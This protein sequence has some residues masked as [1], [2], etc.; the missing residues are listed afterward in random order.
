MNL[1]LDFDQRRTSNPQQFGD[2][3]QLFLGNIPHHATEEELKALFSRFGQVIDLRI[4]SKG[5]GKLPPGARNPLNYGFITYN[6]A[7]AA[8]NCLAN[9]VS[10]SDINDVSYRICKEE[11]EKVFY[12]QVTYLVLLVL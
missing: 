6:D 12:H 5:N 11:L 3:Q 9:C 2:S 10:I 1:F 4:L 8:Q 7:E